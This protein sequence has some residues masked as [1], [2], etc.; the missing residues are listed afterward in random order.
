MDGRQEKF[1]VGSSM[2]RYLC[3]FNAAAETAD[4][5]QYNRRQ[6]DLCAVTK[7]QTI[8]SKNKEIECQNTERKQLT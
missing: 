4:G 2:K 8:L 5:A 6:H 3:G 1:R 7:P